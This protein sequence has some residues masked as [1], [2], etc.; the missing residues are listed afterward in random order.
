MRGG[1]AG[2]A[3][4]IVTPEMGTTGYCWF[5]RAEVKPFVE[6][7]PGPTT[8]IFHAIA[9][10]HRCYIVVGMPE[11]D[12]ASDLYYNTA[13]LIGPDG[14]VGR[15]RKSH[16]YIAEPKW[17]ANGDIVHE[18]F[19]TEIGRISMLVCMDLHFFETARLEA[20]GGADVI[21]HISNWLQERA[22]APTGSTALSKTPAM[23][24]KVTG[25]DWREPCSSPEE[26]A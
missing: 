3:R 25:G 20:L 14:V 15:H 13:V 8:D 2:G 22:P 9:H 6:T 1:R 4:L 7:V 26:A 11:V 24:S 19:E 18:V 16:P 21:C 10:K 17:A 23:S 12:P 5:D